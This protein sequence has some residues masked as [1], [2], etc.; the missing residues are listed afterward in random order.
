MF[1][2][3]FCLSTIAALLLAATA[4]P[5]FAQNNSKEIMAQDPAQLVEILKN[6]DA[7]LFDKAKACQRLAA[8][9]TKDA[10]PALVALLPDEK[11]NLYARFGLEGIPDPAVDDA[12]REAAGKLQGRQQ[13]GVIDSIGQRKDAKAVDLLQGLLGHADAAVASAAAGALGRIGTSEAAAVLQDAVARKSPVKKCLGDACLACAEGLGAGG[14][15]AKALALYDAV[16]AADVPKFQKIAALAGRFQVEKAEAKGLLVEQIRAKDEAQFNLGLSVARWMPGADVTAALTAE[17]EKLPAERQALLLRALGDRKE[18]VSLAVVVAASKSDKPPLREAAI[19]VLAGIGDPSAATILLDAALGDGASAEV[20]REGLKNLP[21][22]EVDGAIVAKLAGADARAKAVLFDLA[23][24]RR[25]AAVA[26]AVRE[27][28]RDADESVRLAAIVA[29]GQLVD[30][31]GFELLTSR[32]LAGGEAVETVAAQ[33]ALKTAALRMADRDACAARLA[34]CL[35]SA[36]AERQQYLLDLLGKV[37]G[38]KALAVV[39]ACVKEDAD[40]KD[41]ATKV[42]GDW[43]NADAAPALLEIAKDDA[44]NKYRVRALRGYIRIARQLQLPDEQR[45]EMFRTAMETAQRNEE[46][47]LALDIL[48]RVP[49]VE[50][51]KLAVSYVGEKALKK[52]A[53]DAAVAIAAALVGPAPKDVAEAMQKLIDAN[54]AGLPG[55]RAKELLDQAR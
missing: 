44:E 52:P 17:L 40:L 36:P 10:I 33:D 30:L 8:A 23:A 47:Q 28:L 11:L 4:G 5:S 49:T 15:K 42:L 43:V 55:A 21:G 12:L 31:D 24:V 41:R 3:R 2:Q 7:P 51:L 16:A 54:V 9:G 38:A 14:K 48:S 39:V 50:S 1:D 35:K 6:S 45:I 20:A 13:V 27:A 29:L 18:R 22:A 32:A 25:I 53:A 19:Q 26:P 37:S 46:K 34:E